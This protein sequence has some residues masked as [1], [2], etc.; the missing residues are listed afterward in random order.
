MRFPER[1]TWSR[2]TRLLPRTRSVLDQPLA[3]RPTARMWGRSGAASPCAP[4][5]PLG[6][7]TNTAPSGSH[8]RAAGRLSGSTPL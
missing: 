1:L 4:A 8:M 5:A 7:S 3:G 2:S 6:R